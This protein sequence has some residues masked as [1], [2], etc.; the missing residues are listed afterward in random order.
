LPQTNKKKTKKSPPIKIQETKENPVF[1]Y[2]LLGLFAVFVVLLTTFLISGDDDVFWHLATGRYIVESGTV[3]STDVFGYVTE[4]QEWM[5]F[6]WGWDI[7]TYGLYNIGGY[8]AISVFRTVIFLLTFGIL[9][10]VMQRFKVSFNI[11][12]LILGLIAFGTIDRLTP[13]PHIISYLFFALLVFIIT[14]Y[15]YIR[16]N[17]KILYFLPLIFLVWANIHMGIIAGMFFLGIYVISEMIVFVRKSKVNSQFTPLSKPDLYRL[18]M[19]IVACILVMLINPNSF[20]TYIY[21]YEHTQMKLLETINEWR[22][23]F[24]E[25]FSGS[26]VT[27]I[28]KIFLFSGLLVLY[29]AVKR[30]DIFIGILVIGLA[31]YSVRAVRLTVD[32]IIFISAFLGVSLDYII[33]NLKA[34]SFKNFILKG[35]VLKVVYAIILLFCIFRLPDSS[36]YLENLKYY[37]ISGMGINSDFIPV[38]MFDFMKENNIPDKGEKVLNHFGT[39]GYLIWNFPQEKNFIDSRNLNDSIYYEYTGIMGMAPGFQQ[40]IE[41]H[42]IDYFIYLAPDLVRIPQEMQTTPISYFSQN[43]Q[44]KLVFWDDKSFLYVKNTPEFAD[45]I[46]KFEYKYVTPYNFAYNRAILEQGLNRDKERFKKEYERKLFEDPNGLIINNYKAQ[47]GQTL[48]Q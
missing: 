16:H 44:W 5:P 27:I 32:Y 46:E 26:F 18:L 43:A 20:Q 48:A 15:K 38:Q 3:P 30:K 33:S 7:I 40:K 13:R 35:P 22:S 42:G 2:I 41:N 4:G 45:I 12:L 37:R 6:E 21:A 1:N 31:I 25:M 47:F 8:E 19:I 28:Y 39:G 17:H 9:F 10:I 29:Y 23:P 14:D 24:N 11:S 34:Q 36:L